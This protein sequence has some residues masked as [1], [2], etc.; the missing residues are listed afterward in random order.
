MQPNAAGRDL[1]GHW[2]Q[3]AN[4]PDSFL[5]PNVFLNEV[6]ISPA[7]NVLSLM[8]YT[9]TGATYQAFPR[10]FLETLLP[11]V[12]V[13]GSLFMGSKLFAD[14]KHQILFVLCLEAFMWVPTN[15]LPSPELAGFLLTLF[16]IGTCLAG[17]RG[18]R[19]IMF[20]IGFVGLVITHVLFSFIFLG[21]L[22][23][24]YLVDKLG[25]SGAGIR[26][27][28]FRTL[29][30]SVLVYFAYYALIPLLLR[31]A[32][33]VV[34]SAF[35]NPHGGTPIYV[36]LTPYQAPTITM[37]WIFIGIVGLWFI[38]MITVE[39]L[40]PFKSRKFITLLAL[41]IPLIG[42]PFT[43]A[44]SD[45]GLLEIFFIGSPL[46]AA[47]LVTVS[48]HRVALMVVLVLILLPFSLGLRYSNH[49]LEP[50][51]EP[52][53][54][55][56]SYL[57]SYNV[58]DMVAFWPMGGGGAGQYANSVPLAKQLEIA[59]WAE[60]GVTSVKGVSLAVMTSVGDNLLLWYESNSALNN[61]D[62]QLA[63]SGSLIYN[64]GGF[65]VYVFQ[66]PVS[67]N[68]T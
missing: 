45:Q 47:A 4:F 43:G 31:E 57:V 26:R 28:S 29:L 41:M 52:V 27:I 33:P 22:L 62:S 50:I 10:N 59:N 16:V 53:F 37:S 61:V 35:Y 30:G 23:V 5:P 51:P 36:P 20:W 14:I 8:L 13:I 1:W 2:F 19:L 44:Y 49:Y 48:Q 24:L 54:A 58:K 42:I 18:S 40:K 6:V 3:S 25:L 15:T 60:G 64:N 17:L 32:I 12:L 21:Y 34:V 46:L 66:Q 11:L 9:A 39:K 7:F 55:G 63:S 65:L 68:Y 67:L 38:G 56:S